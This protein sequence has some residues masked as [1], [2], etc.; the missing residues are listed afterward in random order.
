MIEYVVLA[1]LGILVNI[2]REL[3]DIEKDQPVN[4]SLWLSKNKYNL[5]YSA[6]ACVAALFLLK[7]TQQLTMVNAIMAGYAGDTIVKT[8]IKRK[9]AN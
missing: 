6:V 7:A 5:I 9:T 2:L 8:K 1:I 3:A 4:L